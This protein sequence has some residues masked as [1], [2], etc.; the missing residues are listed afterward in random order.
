MKVAYLSCD[1]GVRLCGTSGASVHVRETV[2][3]LRRLGHDVLA[4]SPTEGADRV[5]PLDGLADE[6]LRFLEDERAGLPDH[7]SKEWRRLLY[8]EQVQRPLLALLAEF[9]PDLIY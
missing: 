4:V 5:L 3:A 1:F 9:Q 2:T 6:A 8:A 7:L